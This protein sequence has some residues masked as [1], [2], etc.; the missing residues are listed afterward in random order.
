MNDPVYSSRQFILVWQYLLKHGTGIERYF[1]GVDIPRHRILD[2]HEWQD[3]HTQAKMQQNYRLCLPDYDLTQAFDISYEMFGSDAYGLISA[4]FRLSSFKYIIKAIPYFVSTA[5]KIDLFRILEFNR[6]SAI[7][8]YTIYPGFEPF[9]NTA[10]VYSFQGVFAV[11]PKL[12]GMPPAKVTVV[13]SF[14]DVFKKFE[15]DFSQFHHQVTEKN[16]VIYLDEAVAGRWI[17][18]NKDIK[19]D[20]VI[21]KHL[22]NERC[23]LWEKDVIDTK[24]SGKQIIIARK[25]DLYNCT[26]TL[27]RLDWEN[28]PFLARLNSFLLYSKQ[29]LGVFLKSR[30]ALFRQSNKLHTHSRIL[31]QRVRE[32]TREVS[33]A[34]AKIIELEK[35][36]VEHRIT[37]GFAHEMR[38][39]LTGAQLEIEAATHYQNSEKTSTE[40]IKD[41]TS[42][43]VEKWLTLAEQ[44]HIPQERI[45]SDVI[46]KLEKINVTADHLADTLSGILNDI[47]RGLSITTQIHNYSKLNIIQV[48]DT[49]LDIVKMFKK[50]KHEYKNEFVKHGIKYT[51]SSRDNLFLKADEVHFNSIFSNLILNARDALVDD[52][53]N[54]PQIHIHIKDMTD[55]VQ[56]SVQDN[57]PGIQKAF[58][59]EIFEPF[60]STKPASGTGFGLGVV[61]RLVTLYRG[62]ITVKS[63][64]GISTQFDVV[65]PK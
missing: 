16:G 4:I 3:I 15:H 59:K 23:I 46:K 25:G 58:I 49:P 13:A 1:D 48:G 36:S 22:A 57:G 38:N 34:H 41:H 6:C 8:E 63:K 52:K 10:H 65:L 40:I 31:E 35:W 44:Y 37:S 60:F 32:K 24:K 53:T 26:K 62:Q 19:L 56:I 33:K 5:S 39:A 14:I 61:K 11:L 42:T 50:F 30:E 54:H 43:L 9:I 51:V 45:V 55:Q 28:K 7:L 17:T 21:H 64:P 29:Y 18:V 12:H 27:Y 20:P 2:E 47:E